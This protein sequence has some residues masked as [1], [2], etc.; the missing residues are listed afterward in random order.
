MEERESPYL[1][2]NVQNSISIVQVIAFWKEIMKVVAIDYCDMFV[3]RFLLRMNKHK[4]QVLFNTG[5][6]SKN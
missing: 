6:V 2:S 4:D 3:K 5:F 1:G